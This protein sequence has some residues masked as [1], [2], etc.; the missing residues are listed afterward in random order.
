MQKAKERGI[1]CHYCFVDFKSAFDTI[2]TK[3]L[4][5]MMRS[6]GVN[7]KIVSIVEKM[8]DK[9]ICAAVT[10][11]LLTEWFSVCVG[12]RQ[13]CLISPILFNLFLDLG[14]DKIKCLQDRVKLDGDLNFDASFADDT[15]LIAGVFERLQLATDQLQE[16]CKRY[17]M[18]ISTEKCKVISDSTTN[19]TIENEEIKI[20][21]EF[22]FLGSL[23]PN[24]SDGVK[25]RIALANSALCRLKK[26]VWS[27]RDI[28]IKLKLRLYNELSNLYI[29]C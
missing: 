14:M 15:T 1:K 10:D 13:G 5:K 7:K 22:K 3:A 6:I 26:S 19:L 18:K 16:A 20:V 11:G 27:R 23:V 2:W 12:V 21:K 9:T 24:S 4:W 28:W 25:R 8:Y 17:G 29:Y